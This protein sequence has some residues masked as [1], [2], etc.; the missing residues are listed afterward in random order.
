M[1]PSWSVEILQTI[2]SQG[3]S[4]P[5]CWFVWTFYGER[6]SE[7]T[8]NNSEVTT[9]SKNEL[10]TEDPLGSTPCSPVIDYGKSIMEDDSYTEEEKIR[11]IELLDKAFAEN[12][13]GELERQNNM[14]RTEMLDHFMGSK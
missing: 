3:Y 7:P 9:K 2:P 13:S 14:T 4:L 10:P 8:A 1:I 6:P 11:N 12:R 5:R